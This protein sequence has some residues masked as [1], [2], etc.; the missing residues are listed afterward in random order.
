MSL[1][2]CLC[3]RYFYK[4]SSSMVKML[5]LRERFEC[6]K[7]VILQ[8]IFP[9][10][11][12]SILLLSTPHRKH[13]TRGAVQL[14]FKTCDWLI[15]RPMGLTRTIGRC[16]SQSESDYFSRPAIGWFFDQWDLTGLLAVVL[17]NQETRTAVSGYFIIRL[18]HC[19]LT[20]VYSHLRKMIG[21]N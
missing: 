3:K 17:A 2:C 8:D 19:I 7:L 9:S 18:S 10:F 16:V 6:S 1:R 21:C 11:W 14:L 15:F 20:L 12:M 5:F 4:G 13:I